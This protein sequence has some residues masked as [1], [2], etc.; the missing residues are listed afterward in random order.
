MKSSRELFTGDG[1]TVAGC[2]LSL[3]VFGLVGEISGIFICR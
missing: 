1:C 3:S 2:A